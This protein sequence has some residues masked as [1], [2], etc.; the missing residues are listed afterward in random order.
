VLSG[1]GNVEHL[2]ENVASLLKPPL[3]QADL[4]RLAQIFGG[5]DSV[6]GN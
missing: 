6:S 4:E 1:T 2:K 3:A 5:V